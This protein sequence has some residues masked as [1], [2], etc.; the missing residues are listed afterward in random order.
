[1]PNV[2]S[3]YETHEEAKASVRA[4]SRVGF[5]VAF[6]TI[7]ENTQLHWRV[8]SF[9]RP[10]DRFSRWIMRGT[11]GGGLIGLLFDT[12]VFAPSYVGS[13]DLTGAPAS[14]ILAIVEWSVFGATCG[15]IFA[16]LLVGLSQQGA[17]RY[18]LTREGSRLLPTAFGRARAIARAQRALML[19]AQQTTCG[20][21]ISLHA[22]ALPSPI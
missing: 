8:A 22:N 2:L 4:L 11:I 1:M 12:A 18:E 10:D 19:A 21:P 5:T 15:A 7:L 20:Q 3:R 14:W 16:S 6:H 17:I 13:L 9:F